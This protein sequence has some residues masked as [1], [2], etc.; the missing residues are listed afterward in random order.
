MIA[1]LPTFSPAVLPSVPVNASPLTK[2]GLT[3]YV[4]V[5]F[6]APYTLLWLASAVTVIGFA[7]TTNVWFAESASK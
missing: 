2:A 1:Y 5:G 7:F 4:Y 6:E 3:V